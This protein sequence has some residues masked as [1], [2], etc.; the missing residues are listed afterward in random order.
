MKCSIL[1]FRE[2]TA[3]K[4]PAQR[5]SVDDTALHNKL[6]SKVAFYF[7]KGSED[8][9]KSV[10]GTSLKEIHAQYK[11]KTC[12]VNY[13]KWTD[14]KICLTSMFHSPFIITDIQ[15]QQVLR[16]SCSYFGKTVTSDLRTHLPN[17]RQINEWNLDRP[18]VFQKTEA[19]R[20][21]ENQHMNLESLSGLHTGRL[22]PPENTPGTHFC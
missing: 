22:F 16:L 7:V 12:S 11:N 21:H 1:K 17:F 4:F 15:L 19:P 8:G 14:T 18:W 9:R 5:V 13:L 20:F 6:K 3:S 10:I 2:I